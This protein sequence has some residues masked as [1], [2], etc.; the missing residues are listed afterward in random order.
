MAAY[1][2]LRVG[3]SNAARPSMSTRDPSLQVSP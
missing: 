1:S 2:L 3:R